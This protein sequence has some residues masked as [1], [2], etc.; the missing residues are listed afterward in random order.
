MNPVLPPETD[1]KIWDAWLNSY[2]GAAISVALELQIFEKLKDP[3]D[4]ETL[5]QRTGFST[6]G[7]TALLAM[8]K[9]LGF[10][11]RRDEA[12]QLNAVSRSYLLQE[13]PFFWGPFFSRLAVGLPSYKLLLENV[14][15]ERTTEVRAA[16]GWE[17]GEIDD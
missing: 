16:E 15:D 8:L 6:R 7:L 4:V 12:Y 10:L 3:A 5:R 11:D 13:S 1:T 17:S 2:Q 14:R 9:C